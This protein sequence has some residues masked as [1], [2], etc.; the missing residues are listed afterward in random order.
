MNENIENFLNYLLD[1]EATSEIAFNENIHKNNE[2]FHSRYL[3]D[4]EFLVNHKLQQ[5]HPDIFVSTLSNVDSGQKSESNDS[6]E[7]SS[8]SSSDDDEKVE[9]KKTFP[10]VH[11]LHSKESTE[12]FDAVHQ[13]RRLLQLLRCCQQHYH[14]FVDLYFQSLDQCIKHENE[15]IV[16]VALQQIASHLSE[17]ID[18]NNERKRLIHCLPSNMSDP[19]INPLYQPFFDTIQLLLSRNNTE[20]A[21]ISLISLND[22]DILYPYRARFLDVRRE[23]RDSTHYFIDGDSLLLSIA[24]HT[25]VDLKSYYGNTLHVIFIIERIL[26]TLFN[27]SHQC[28][29][30]LLFFD[31]HY[32]LYRQETSILGLL[33]SCL[34]VHLSKNADKCGITKV[35]QFS[36]W[37][38]DKYS[39]F[40]RDEKP[41]FI[42]YHDMANF[43]M[44][45]GSLLSENALKQLTI[46][47]CLFGNYHQNIIKCHLYLMNKLILTETTVQCFEIQFKRQFPTSL[48]KKII[49][50]VPNQ[51]ITITKNQKDQNEYEKFCQNICQDDIRLFLYLKAIAKFINNTKDQELVQL[52]CPLFILHVALLIRLSLLDRHLPSSFPSITFSPMLSQMIAQFQQY[53]SSNLSSQVSSLSW[54]KVADLF[55]GHLFAFTLYRL[56]SSSSNIR[57]DS[58]TYEIVRESLSILNI[59]FS[60]DLFQ[61]VVNQ[62]IQLNV[63]D[64]S[65]S[66]FEQ[67]S[68]IVKRIETHRKITKISNRFINTLLQPIFSSNNTST[69]EWVTPNDI[70]ATRYEGRHHW[71][72]YKEV[73]DEVSR[74]RDDDEQY[75]QRKK[76][77]RFRGQQ[78]QQYYT[79]FTLYGK[80]L[81]SRD[82]KDNQMQIFLPTTFTSLPN[83]EENSIERSDSPSSASGSK[84]KQQHKKQPNKIQLKKSE[85]IIKENTE[86]KMNKCMD[87]ETHERTNVEVRLKQIPT[88]NYSDAIDLIDER[89]PNFKTSTIRLEL[90]KRKFDLQQKYLRSLKKKHSLT[91]EEKSK[92]ELL[93]I[94]FFATMTE[95]VHLENV[96]DVFA[97]KRK[98]MEELVDDSVLDREKWYRF[99]MEKINSRLPRREQGIRDSRVAADFIPDGWQVEFLNA[100]DAE[101]SII[102]V[103]PTASGKTYASYYAMKHVLENEDNPNGICVYVAPTKALVNQVAATIYSKFGPIFGLF[104]RDYR[105]KVDE[106]R[107]L[108]TV[109]H[110]L[111]I[112]LLSPNYQR[113]CQ[114]IQYCIFDEIHCMSGELGSDVWEKTMLLINCPMIGLSATVNN[115]KDLCQWIQHVEKQRS[116]LYETLEPRQ[117]C[118]IL[119]HERL[120]D[121]NKYLYSN[122]QLHPI[123]PIGLMNAKQIITRGLPK[124]FSLSPNE[125]LRLKDAMQNVLGQTG[126]PVCEDTSRKPIPTL[127]EYFSTD[128]IIE[129][130]K[131]NNYS[132]LVSDQFNQLITN[133]QNSTI[134]SIVQSINSVGSNDFSYPEQ[135]SISTVIVEFVLTLKEKNLLPCITFMDNRRLCEKL[136]ESVTQ[137]LEEVENE[138]RRTKYKRQIEV[139]E[140]RLTQFEK[141]QKSA[142][143]K[144]KVRTPDKCSNSKSSEL[145]EMEEEDDRVQYQ[146]SGHEQNLLYGIL[147]EGTLANR[148]GCDQELVSKLL[149]RAARYNQ[150]LVQYMK[151]GV[152]YHHA[153]LNNKERTAVEALFRN[154][155]VQIIFSTST[156]ALGIHMPT[157]TVAFVKDSIFLDALQYRQSSGRA[158]RRGFDIQGHVVFINIPISKICHLTIS[159]IPDIHSHFPTSVTFFMRLLHLYSNAKNKKDAMNRS[160]ITLECPFIKQS[161]IKYHLIDVQTRYHCLHTLDFLHRL[162][163]ING[164]GDLIGL[165]GLLTHLH[166]FEPANILLVYLM[167]T[168]L[169][170][171]LNHDIDIV[172]VL[173]RLFTNIPWLVTHKQFENL[174]SKRRQQMFNSKL[175]LSKMLINFSERVQTYNSIVKDVYGFYIE[176]VIRHLRSLIDNQEQILPFS[177]ISFSQLSDYDNGTFEYTLH[178]HYSQQTL[179]PSISPFSAPSGLTH[180]KFMSNYNPTVGSWDLAYDV[181]LST[182]IVPFIDIDI[183]DH[184]NSAYYLNSYAVDFFNHGSEAS[185]ILENQINPGETNNLLLDFL[186]M[187]SSIKTSLEIIIRNE[188]EQATTN[189]IQFFQPLFEKI[190]NIKE[191]FAEKF[192]KAYPY[193]RRR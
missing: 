49:E 164:E 89:L 167:D 86:R 48:L 154:R 148:R 5:V 13:C 44:E 85:I 45:N 161:R 104:T 36:S 140:E 124:D 33:R 125:T 132:S 99:Q 175:F 66:T 65:R 168:Q 92:L 180:E 152:A 55:D 190:S 183:R 59:P 139:L 14:H 43:D 61:N 27:Q 136:A 79:Y 133:Q 22:I 150:R 88:D 78:K 118:F 80:S 121:L 69:F 160:L 51:L 56:S 153:E 155:Y 101:Q 137:Y 110:C 185:L 68:I 38:D 145:K 91:I 75:T 28:N 53:L 42:F 16:I 172:N 74:I 10:M 24:H 72:V 58:K 130:C 165:A 82:I 114:R 64:F 81:T 156:L 39:E 32:E 162:N 2:L 138:L 31:C 18:D 46:I 9:D 105:V 77:P 41:L 6:E 123:H 149:K 171:E 93:Q 146:L 179:N 170:H 116:E 119:H 134:D 177:N 169:F 108:V 84:K 191:I 103:A 166:Y 158:G 3:K 129:R 126:E 144:K 176:N 73:G 83:N 71:H 135:K 76:N 17:N 122:R 115:G 15:K 178:H 52:L 8:T 29:Y 37:L 62:M 19:T 111:E 98:Y 96:E 187:L 193:A 127:S 102:I 117:V 7:E 54:S 100:V 143:G 109:P 120:A 112:L 141:A 188:N 67:S 106:C 189:D 186:M 174:V 50:L 1:T 181:D 182:R 25:N 35:Q 128:W 151:R 192:Y 159:A 97:E 95:I 173:A 26:L 21:M 63:V 142:K 34:I 60:D 157:K 107:I 163:L 23:F 184:T 147:D 87:D 40:V 90:L 113:W 11:S 131:C 12:Y 20:Q 4:W 30:T 94:E 70:P 57:F 47:Y